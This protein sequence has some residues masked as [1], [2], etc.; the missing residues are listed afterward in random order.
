MNYFIGIK[1]Y[2]KAYLDLRKVEIIIDGGGYRNFSLILRDKIYT[3][4]TSD[5]SRDVLLYLSKET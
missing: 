4:K 2:P 3:P 1:E 5:D